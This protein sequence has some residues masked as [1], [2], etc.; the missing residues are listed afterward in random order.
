MPS[1]GEIHQHGTDVIV[2]EVQCTPL[3]AFLL[4]HLD[5]AAGYATN[6]A[7]SVA[8]GFPARVR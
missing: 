4:H 1:H 3:A 5:E 6:V 2:V 8:P 7:L